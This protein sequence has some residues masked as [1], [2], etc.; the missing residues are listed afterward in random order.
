[1]SID[2]EGKFGAALHQVAEQLPPPRLDLDRIRRG[3][4][5]R[6]A[7]TVSAVALVAA[8]VVAG[9]VTGALQLGASSQAGS[10]LALPQSHPGNGHLSA[11]ARVRASP[12]PAAAVPPGL[13][14][15]IA[16]VRAFYSRYATARRHGRAVV[17]A[18][19][20]HW[21]ASWYVPIFE[22]S[23]GT[24]IDPVECG[25]RALAHGLAYKP[26]EVIGGQAV[27]VVGSRLG[28]GQ[29]ASHAVVTADP[30][31]G[32]IT[33]I[34]CAGAGSEVTETGARDAVAS[35]YQTY[36]PAR[37]QGISVPDAVARLQMGGPDFANPYLGQVRQVA[38]RRLLTYDPLLCRPDGGPSLSEGAAT[39]V[40]GGSA[41]VVAVTPRHARPIVA[42]VVLGA[43]G[44]IV[45]GVA[46]H[47]P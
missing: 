40:A 1:M 39:I 2:F 34:T 5:R 47:K 35:L 42:V 22:A 3:G 31:T 9:A 7:R 12:H 14:T 15:A 41:G 37:R 10:P 6:R 36:V 11:S 29:L 33:G 24:G 21:T 45:A 4:R 13:A 17:D 27:I 32:K 20:R 30:R 38:S 23:P 19:I 46:C 18:L 43:K 16:D 44:W 8:V 25:I 26:V 28:A